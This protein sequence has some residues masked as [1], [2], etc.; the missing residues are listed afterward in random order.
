M[1]SR[2]QLLNSAPGDDEASRLKREIRGLEEELREARSEAQQAKQASADAISA[3]RALRK[4]TEGLFNAL[5]MI[6][7]EISR[8]DAEQ[9]GT[10][11][12][13]PMPNQDLW[14]ERIAKVSGASA[15]ILQ[16]LLDGGGPMAYSQ[17]KSAARSG[18][19][20]PAR[21]AELIARNWVERIGHGSYALKK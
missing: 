5:R 17:I 1:S 20:T 9:L 11:E 3:I 10:V 14:R 7:G 13:S 15:R 21:L 16:V 8:V 4:Q 19:G 2:P 18:G 12:A 6:H